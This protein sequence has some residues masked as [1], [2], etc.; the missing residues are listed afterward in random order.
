[1]ET[2]GKNWKRSA[3]FGNEMETGILV[4]IAAP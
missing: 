3:F 2:K 4:S 1:M